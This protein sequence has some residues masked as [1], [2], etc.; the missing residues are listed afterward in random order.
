MNKGQQALIRALSVM[1][2]STKKLKSRV[3]KGKCICPGCDR[4]LKSRGLCEVH[5]QE[6]Y[7]KKYALP[8]PE[9]RD[10][11][12]ASAIMHGII[13]RKYEQQQWIREASSPFAKLMAG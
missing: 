10:E 5:R 3:V 7:A 9:Q 12:E 13:L 11:Y 6:F 2:K 1:R 8:T 4:P